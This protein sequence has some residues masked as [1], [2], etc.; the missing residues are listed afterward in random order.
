MLIY[1]LSL[2]LQSNLPLAVVVDAV[3]HEQEIVHYDVDIA[4]ADDGQSIRGN[5]AIVYVVTGGDG[6]LVLDFDRGLAID[7]VVAADQ[8]VAPDRWRWIRGARVGDD[9]LL[10]DHWGRVG[11]TLSVVVSYRGRPRDGLTLQ[12]NVHG[13][14]TAFADN[15][16]NRAHHWF[17]SEDHP[18]DKATVTFAV[19]VPA[20][21][22]A[23]ANG[24]LVRVDTATSGRT[25]W[26]W[27]AGRPI[28]VYTM[29]I[30]AGKMTE[31]TLGHAGGVPN[32][33]W[34]FSEDS[35]FAVE[36]PLRRA[37]QMVEVFTE[38]VGPF[39]YEKLAHV[40]SSTQFGGMENSSA[41][42]YSERRY[43]D[44]TMGEGVV[45]HEIAHQWFG[46]AVTEFDWHHLWLSE[47]FASYF[48]PLFF[49]LAGDEDTFRAMMDRSRNRY[50]GSAV[51][52]RPVIDVREEDLFD[53]L[54]ANNYQKG[55]WILH[56]LRNEIG[57]SAF[58]RGVREYYAVYRD[59]AALSND[60]ARIMS[61][62]AG[63][64]LDWFFEQWL[65]QPGHPEIKATWQYHA[66]RRTVTLLAEQVQ[67]ERWG[68]F[69]IT[70]PV[71]L[72]FASEEDRRLN[73]RVSGRQTTLVLRDVSAPPTNV[74]LDPEGTV[75][76]AVTTVSGR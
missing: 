17:P 9:L 67:P 20:G 36:G 23:I 59:S 11:D 40:Q 12:N 52:N 19:E 70:L 25:T 69:T 1:A 2:L 16:P 44:R 51:V 56:T 57:D 28:P 72:E 75:L 34:T 48:G 30:G 50:L 27:S 74:L 13:R 37:N 5:V 66:D 55:A 53:L 38:L 45:A 62:H 73:A 6:P 60:L 76:V 42:F 71:V 8:R 7:S 14:P 31:A 10:V 64:S 15:W 21:W 47:G 18:N 39:P 24:R 29:V 54:N 26:R 32:T 61:A 4:I 41:I 63:Q 3:R 58:F 49:A 22:R 33:A 43:A 46:D 65:L 35:A 68:T